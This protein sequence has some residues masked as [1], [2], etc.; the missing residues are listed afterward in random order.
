M[1]GRIIELS[2]IVSIK[3]D[4]H[5]H[6]LPDIDCSG[7][8]EISVKLL[9]EMKAAG[10]QNVVLTPHFYPQHNNNVEDFLARRDRHI[11]HL[12]KE[13]EAENLSGIELIAGAEVLLCPRLEKLKNL[14]KLCI[15][16]TNTILIEMP[17]LP[18]SDMLFDSLRKMRN[19]LGLEVVIAHA[20]RYGKYNAMYL[21]DNMGFKVQVN[22][23]S[24]IS[25]SMKHTIQDWAKKGYVC[26]LGSDKHVHSNNKSCIYKEF[27]KASVALEKYADAINEQSL[28]LIG[29]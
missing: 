18:W 7:N 14:E 28:K 3:T 22:S 21:M 19:R 15:E 8:P 4:F 29:K 2:N 25:F 26:A 1:N 27:P 9:R 20:D 5:T 10:V 17:D 11:R 6:L 13:M 23:D 12:L 16:G 24:T